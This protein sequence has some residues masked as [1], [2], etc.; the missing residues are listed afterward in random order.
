MGKESSAP[1]ARRPGPRH[2][3]RRRQGKKQSPVARSHNPEGLAEEKHQQQHTEVGGARP[4]KALKI[5]LGL[6]TCG[7]DRGSQRK[8]AGRALTVLYCFMGAHPTP[9]KTSSS[10]RAGTLAT[11]GCD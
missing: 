6:S 4:H 11:T 7:V 10:L 3:G 1:E 8:V 5:Q 9:Q 2:S